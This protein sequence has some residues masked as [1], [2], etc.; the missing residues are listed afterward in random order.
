MGI[1][2]FTVIA[3]GVK[4]AA[5]R[6]IYF[7]DEKHRNHA[8]TTDIIELYG[9]EKTTLNII[10]M[11]EERKL[12]LAKNRKGGRPPKEGTE[13]VFSLP[14]GDEFKPSK[15]QWTAMLKGVLKDACEHMGIDGKDILPITRAVAHQQAVTNDGRA[16]GD[17]MHVMIG[18]CTLSGQKLE[19]NDRG[20]LKTLKHGWNNQIR[21]Q[22]GICHTTYNAKKKYEGTAKKRAPRWKVNAAKAIDKANEARELARQD[23][24]NIKFIDKP[25]MQELINNAEG[26]IKDIIEKMERGDYLSAKNELEN[27][28]NIIEEKNE[29]I[30]GLT[31][32]ESQKQAND[33]FSNSIEKAQ[34]S[35]NREL[36]KHE[37]QN[38]ENKSSK[39]KF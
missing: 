37:N 31:C 30:S 38:P 23:R 17:H 2:N 32:D 14:N 7:T 21:L 8:N 3:E 34:I 5:A 15:E 36:A 27:L 4:S 26:S 10:R 16:G 6:E 18:N 28:N 11:N 1:K 13:F 24:L 12:S 19:L 20:L 35:I 9:N 39:M 33:L 29:F 25:A 22:M